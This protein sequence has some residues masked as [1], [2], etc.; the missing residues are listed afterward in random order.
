DGKA[1]QVRQWTRRPAA[2]PDLRLDTAKLVVLP[3]PL[4]TGDHVRQ[5]LRIDPNQ[6]DAAYKNLDADAALTLFAAE[7]AS[8][9]AAVALDLY[10]VCFHDRGDKRIGFYTL[11]AA[12]VCDL[13]TAGVQDV[14]VACPDEP[15]ARY[16]AFHTS[17]SRRQNHA[18]L[19]DIG[20]PRDG[21]VQRL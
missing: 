18:E 20:G 8:P 9:N 12:C 2:A 14:L 3:L 6:G 5:S 10:R 17:P 7:S 15:F 21:F 16:L 11:L 1:V 13:G 4:R 19:G